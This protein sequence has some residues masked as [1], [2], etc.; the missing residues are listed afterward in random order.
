MLSN[1]AIALF[2]KLFLLLATEWEVNE[3]LA[4][5]LKYHIMKLKGKNLKSTN[6]EI[7]SLFQQRCFNENK[8]IDMS[9]LPPWKS[10]F[11]LHLRRVSYYRYLEAAF[12]KSQQW[13]KF[14]Y[15]S[16]S[17]ENIIWI[18][19]AFPKAIENILVEENF[20]FD[21]SYGDECASEN[22]DSEWFKNLADCVQYLE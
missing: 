13:N 2:L 16:F 17:D 10:T 15:G 14:E 9:P 8:A 6:K 1:Y 7:Y 5:D 4:N 21:E 19:D 12:A 20:D 11:N 3:K 22:Q 18:K